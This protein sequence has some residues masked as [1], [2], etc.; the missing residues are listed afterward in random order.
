M[1]RAVCYYL[2]C[3]VLPLT[4]TQNTTLDVGHLA[5]VS[6]RPTHHIALFL[7][8]SGESCALCNTLSAM[9]SGSYPRVET[10]HVPVSCRKQ[11]R[12]CTASVLTE[13]GTGLLCG[14][15]T[16]QCCLQD[17]ENMLPGPASKMPDTK[18]PISGSPVATESTGGG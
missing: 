6:K 9:P 11:L 2:H 14:F 5:S 3:W 13:Q 8:F 16:W 4:V 10:C 17:T 1:V 15:V 7:P 12:T 18:P